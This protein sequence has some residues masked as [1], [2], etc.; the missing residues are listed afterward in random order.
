MKSEMM[1]VGRDFYLSR[2]P[3][4]AS[5]ATITHHRVVDPERF[6]ESQRAAAIA[7]IKSGRKTILD[8]LLVVTESIYREANGL[9]EIVR[10][11]A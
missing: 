9:K 11:G 5:R 4:G 6:L 10:S 8:E 3:H 7:E 2:K 1:P